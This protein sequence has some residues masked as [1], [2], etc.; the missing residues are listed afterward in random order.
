[1][2]KPYRLFVLV[3]LLGGVVIS[4]LSGT[5][6]CTFGGCTEAHKYRLYGFSFP[7]VGL[8]F[9]V[10]ATLAVLVINRI[11]YAPFLYNLLL[12]GASGAEINMI[13]LQKNVIGLWCPLCIAAAI[14]VYILAA[15][16]MGLYLISCKEEFQMNLKYLGKPLLICVTAMVGFILTFSG[17]AKEE[18]SAGQLDLYTGKKDS[19]VEVYFFSDWFCPFCSKVEEAVEAVYPD[20]AKKTRILFVDKVIHQESLNFVPYH[21]SFEAY[22]KAKIMQ[23]RKALFAVALKTKNPSYDDINAAIAPLKVTYRQLNFLEVTQQMAHSQKLAEQFKVV[24]TPTM[25]VRNAKSGKTV[26]LVG[27]GQIT[28]AGIMKAVKDVE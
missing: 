15:W 22:E 11:P 14:I 28:P 12:A 2:S 6:I 24:S 25:V 1:M 7:V 4:I 3:L 27:N 17:M 21:L 13:L 10:L 5:D 8:S 16:Q 19:K 26:T 18:A 20:L 23:L 9:F